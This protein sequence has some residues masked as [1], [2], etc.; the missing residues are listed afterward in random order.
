MAAAFSLMILAGE[1]YTFSELQKIYH[2]AGFTKVAAHSIPHSPH[3]AV[4]GLAQRL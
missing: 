4:I 2:A 1:A 3:T